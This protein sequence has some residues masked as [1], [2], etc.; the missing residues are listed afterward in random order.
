MFNDDIIQKFSIRSLMLL[1]LLA[2]VSISMFTAPILSGIIYSISNASTQS[3]FQLAHAQNGDDGSGEGDNSEPSFSSSSPPPAESTSSTTTDPSLAPTST[4][5]DPSLAPTS[6]TTDRSTIQNPVTLIEPGENPSSSSNDN[7]GSQDLDCDDISDR[8]FVVSSNDPNGFDGDNDGISCETNGGDNSNGNLTTSP[9]DDNEVPD[10][11]CL[12]NP[13]LPKC[14]SVDGECPDGFFQNENEQCVPE[15]GCP[16]GY[17]TVDDDETGRC[18]PNSDGCPEGMIFRSDGKTCGYK[19][20][21]C[22]DNP[23]LEGVYKRHKNAIT[24]EMMMAMV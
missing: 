21:L 18:I 24:I 1:S 9:E 22:Q 11:D 2:I 8:N 7:D 13:D 5:T 12:Y 6:T 14:V 4:T 16:V 10:G 20:D 3:F 15:G 17:H 19:Q 23:S